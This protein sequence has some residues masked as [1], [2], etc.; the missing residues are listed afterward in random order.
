MNIIRRL[1]ACALTTALLLTGCGGSGGGNE[2]VTPGTETASN[3]SGET[4]ST[5]NEPK[6]ARVTAIGLENAI[7][8]TGDSTL[9]NI[10]VTY[11][12]SR[13]EQNGERVTV[14]VKLPP[15]LQYAVDSSGIRSGGSSSE[16]VANVTTCADGS[17]FIAYDFGVAELDSATDPDGREDADFELIFV[18]DGTGL[19]G[20]AVISS[21]AADNALSFSCE[22]NF[23][24]EIATGIRVNQSIHKQY[25]VREIKETLSKEKNQQLASNRQ[26]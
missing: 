8:A 24:E 1:N 21:A 5:P 22:S 3:G 23:Q 25:T 16:A 19:T 13:V 14:V 9:V 12:E 26:N 17:S 4:T 18:A 7:L 10:D 11:G 6:D 15:G 20:E 2:E